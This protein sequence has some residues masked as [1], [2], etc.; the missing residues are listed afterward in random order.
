M[1]I[2]ITAQARYKPVFT[3]PGI[4]GI[5]Y[6]VGR[7]SS[8]NLKKAIISTSTNI[9]GISTSSVSIGTGSKVFTIDLSKS[10]TEANSTIE[11]TSAGSPSNKMSGTVTSLVGTT[12]TVNVTTATGSGTFSDWKLS[13]HY[14]PNSFELTQQ[15]RHGSTVAPWTVADWDFRGMFAIHW[16][17][18]TMKVTFSQ[19][20]FDMR[21]FNYSNYTGVGPFIGVRSGTA[22]FEMDHCT[23]EG[24]WTTA[25][26]TCH[27]TGLVSCTYC[28]YSGLPADWLAGGLGGPAVDREI[29]YTVVHVVDSAD[30]TSGYHADCMQFFQGMGT[31]TSLHIH[32]CVFAIEPTPPNGIGITAPMNWSLENIGSPNWSTP[33]TMDNVIL[34][35]GS[36]NIYCIHGA[37][38]TVSADID[39]GANIYLGGGLFGLIHKAILFLMLQ[40]PILA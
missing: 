28:H 1:S 14:P 8:N 33:T 23:V 17:Q 24:A 6:A 22:T 12:L 29:A 39:L 35:G 3:A 31:S 2:G 38:T 13:A 18:N 36:Y 40:K 25:P 15:L 37:G 9:T 16:I 10:S 21:A 20:L 4:P 32:H 5:D 26:L 11:L 19:C 7:T 30:V 27:G 34:T